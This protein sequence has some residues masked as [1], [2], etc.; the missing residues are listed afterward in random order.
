MKKVFR[1]GREVTASEPAASDVPPESFHCT[2]PSAQ[3]IRI[4]GSGT[5]R[6]IGLVPHQIITEPLEYAVDSPALPDLGRDILKVVVVNRYRPGPC[7]VG[8]VHG[9]GFSGGAIASSVSHDTHN[10]VA[11]GTS[12]P[13]I[14]WAIDEVIK[15]RGAMVAVS[16][17][18][19]TILPLDCAGLMSTLPYP[20]VAA[21]LAEL[22]RTT[23]LMGGIS[24]PFMY[25]SFLALTVIPSLRITDRGL[26]DGIAFRDVPLFLS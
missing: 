25:L 26:F 8:L 22:G 4:T 11:V 19:R 13:E 21:R 9:F 16:G 20:Q 5:A 18:T 12:D 2:T 6:V 15:A 10:I 17:N 24:D 7:G 23:R 1:G 14:L 3:S